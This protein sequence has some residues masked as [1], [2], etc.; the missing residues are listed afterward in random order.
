MKLLLLFLSLGASLLMAKDTFVPYQT[1][2]EVPRTVPELWKGY[3]PTVEPLDMEVVTT[4]EEDG[5]ICKYVIY[6]V[7]TVKGVPSRIAAYYTYP[8]GGTDLPA[9]VWA[10]GG[11]QRADKSRG[12]YFAKKGYATIDIN[13]NGRELEPGIDKNTDWGMV[14]PSQGKPFYTRKLRERS[15]TPE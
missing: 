2:E 12:I 7:A 9:F 14:D 3:D 8:E 4:F 11:G 1:D 13:W 10:H 15:A 5:I 6:T